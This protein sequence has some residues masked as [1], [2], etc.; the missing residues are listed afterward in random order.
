MSEKFDTQA[1]ESFIR[2]GGSAWEKMQMT[3]EDTDGVSGGWSEA[4]LGWEIR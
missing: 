2:G 1:T 4:I 3:Y